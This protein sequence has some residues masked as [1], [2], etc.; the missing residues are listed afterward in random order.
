MD[1]E[2]RAAGLVHVR[3]AIDDR[4]IGFSGS[5]GQWEWEGAE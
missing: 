2:S 4:L 3:F 1:G 5:W